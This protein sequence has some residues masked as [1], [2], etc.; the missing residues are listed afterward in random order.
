MLRIFGKFIGNCFE[1]FFL[2]NTLGEILWVEFFERNLLG[3]ML[4]KEFFGRNSG[5]DLYVKIFIFVKILSQ[6]RRGK[7]GGRNS[8]H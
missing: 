7:I 1:D 4:W 2:R 3:G 5:I 8:D 6:G